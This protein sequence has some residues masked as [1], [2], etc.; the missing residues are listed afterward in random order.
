MAFLISFGVQIT[1]QLLNIVSQLYMPMLKTIM[2]SLL[3]YL[4]YITIFKIN[5]I[6]HIEKYQII[7]SQAAPVDTRHI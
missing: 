4:R 7:Q 6:G 3:S 5:Y 1:P 2:V